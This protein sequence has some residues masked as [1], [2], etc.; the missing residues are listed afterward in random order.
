MRWFD[1]IY[2]L[3]LR[4]FRKNILTRSL[5]SEVEEYLKVH[6]VKPEPEQERNVF[7]RI[8]PIGEPD[9]PEPPE[10]ITRKK[11]E[12]YLAENKKVSF[13]SMLFM[14][15]DERGERD[16][17]IYKRAFVDRRVFSRIRCDSRYKPMPITAIRLGLALQL[18]RVNFDALLRTAGY[19]L[20]DS[21]EYDLI[22]A[23]C[24]EHKIYN[25]LDINAI[26][27]HYTGT[28]IFL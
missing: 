12:K 24:I 19:A 22:I 1:W 8:M 5:Q 9:S 18:D 26:L 16:S 3:F 23:F 28:T 2:L 11:L 6:Y 14:L 17:D 10:N 27:H 20:S 21:S 15:I 7:F 25:F 13:G 4:S